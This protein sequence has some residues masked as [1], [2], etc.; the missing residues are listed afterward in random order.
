MFCLHFKGLLYGWLW[1]WQICMGILEA[2]KQGNAGEGFTMGKSCH[3]V[4]SIPDISWFLSVIRLKQHSFL[5][6]LSGVRAIYLGYDFTRYH[7]WS[8]F[9][10]C[11]WVIGMSMKSIQFRKQRFKRPFIDFSTVLN[12]KIHTLFRTEYVAFFGNKVLYLVPE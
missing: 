4:L 1:N 5:S 6:G 9:A 7:Q 3:D 10:S 2:P 12:S 11:N 8:S